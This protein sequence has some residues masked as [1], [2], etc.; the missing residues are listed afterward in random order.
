MSNALNVDNGRRLA[1]WTA[2]AAAVLGLLTVIL[3]ACSM[4]GDLSVVYQPAVFLSLPAS[5]HSMFHAAMVADS[6]GFYLAFL[7]IGGYLW[8]VL[9]AEHGA[10]IDMAA[11]CIVTYAL[12]GVAGAS[13]LFA[14]VA[15][16]AAMH[17][18]GDLAVKAATEA[19][20][21]AIATATQQG[22]WLMEGPVMGFWGLVMG[23]AMSA[24]GM[25]YGRLLMVVG[26]LYAS[27][28]VVGV[29][30][31]WA[32]AEVIQTAF[33][34]LLPLWAL[35]TGIALLRQPAN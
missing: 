28:F 4:G 13:V 19:S 2:I 5:A 17:A 24:S 31:L 16:L 14:S 1:G 23:K 27:V 18:A 10:L 30:Q 26:A 21:L 11:L 9:R 22:L 6:L 32:V 3:F 25:P 33:L 35:L 12:L 34:V 15:P 20:W 7:L 29:L 8:S